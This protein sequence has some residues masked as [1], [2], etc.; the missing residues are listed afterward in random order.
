MITS[1]MATARAALLQ[2]AR[3]RASA[4]CCAIVGHRTSLANVSAD[5][6][7]PP[8]RMTSASTLAARRRARP[9]ASG[10]STRCASRRYRRATRAPRASCCRVR[11]LPVSRGAA[12]T[13]PTAWQA[14]R[15]APVPRISHNSTS[16]SGV[17]TRSGRAACCRTAGR[18]RTRRRSSRRTPELS[19]DPQ[20]S[21]TVDTSMSSAVATQCAQVAD[22]SRVHSADDVQLARRAAPAGVDRPTNVRRPRRPSLAA[23]VCSPPKQ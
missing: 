11:S 23:T 5:A 10:G 3:R 8:R 4:R 13:R 6:Y 14:V 9:R 1:V 12:T 16:F 7:K 22:P 19:A 20:P 15:Q 18:L 17:A 21:R 2:R